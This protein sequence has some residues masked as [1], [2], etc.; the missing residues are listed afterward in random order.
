M[1]VGL[2]MVGIEFGLYG[3]LVDERLCVGEWL[4]VI[5]DVNGIWLFMHVGKYEG[6]VVVVNIFGE[7]CE[8]NYD[9]VPCVI[10]IDF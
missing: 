7:L 6:E 3:V 10:Y 4:W 1:D 2:E 8:A 5:G 9:V